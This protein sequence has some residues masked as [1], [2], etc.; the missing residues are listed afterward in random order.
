MKDCVS[1]MHLYLSPMSDTCRECGIAMLNYEERKPTTNADR[2]RGKSDEELAKAFD[3]IAAHKRP[4]TYTAEGFCLDDGEMSETDW[5]S[6]LK[7]PAEE[8]K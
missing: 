8:E 4:S 5:L 3:A 1:C 2:I 6:W 7:A